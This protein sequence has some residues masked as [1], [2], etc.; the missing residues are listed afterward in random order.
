MTDV[1]AVGIFLRQLIRCSASEIATPVCALV[2]NDKRGKAA[3]LLALRAAFG[4][5]ALYTPAGVVVRN[6]TG[7]AAPWPPYRE[8]VEHS[9]TGESLRIPTTQRFRGM[10]RP[11]VSIQPGRVVA[12]T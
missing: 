2:R 6:D 3:A 1:T 7:R 5:C 9:E 4:G 8:A 12:E 10:M 11:A